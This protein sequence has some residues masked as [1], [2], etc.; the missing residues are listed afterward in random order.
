MVAD[1]TKFLGNAKC[2]TPEFS[3]CIDVLVLTIIY[4]V[5]YNDTFRYITF[6]SLSAIFAPLRES[7][8]FNFK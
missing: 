8:E 1:A 6:V 2:L 4:N 7:H 5:A 3:F